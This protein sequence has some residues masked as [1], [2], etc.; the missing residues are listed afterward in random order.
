[1]LIAGRS[2]SRN[3]IVGQGLRLPPAVRIAF[4]SRTMEITSVVIATRV[5]R[6]AKVLEEI[7]R[8]DN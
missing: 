6:I 5:T 2:L 1:M 3:P 7:E 4:D 8:R